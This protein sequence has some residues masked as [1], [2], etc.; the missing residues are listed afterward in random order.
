MCFWG[1][2][3]STPHRQQRDH[4]R[5]WR[6][7]GN[8]NTRNSDLGCGYHNRLKETGYRPVR[9]PDGRYDLLRPDGTRI[10]PPA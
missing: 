8:T 2:C 3:T 5:S 4:I 9:R 6:S 10:T 7:A 1:D